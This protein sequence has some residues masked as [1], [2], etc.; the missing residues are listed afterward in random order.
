MK[1]NRRTQ[2]R[3]AF[4]VENFSAIVRG[5]VRDY[6]LAK[7]RAKHLEGLR[8]PKEPNRSFGES[9]VRIFHGRGRHTDPTEM[10]AELKA[11]V[12]EVTQFLGLSDACLK[13]VGKI[14]WEHPTRKGPKGKRALAIVTDTGRWVRIRQK[15][16]VDEAIKLIDE[17]LIKV[18][19]GLPESIKSPLDIRKHFQ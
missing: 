8:N 4:M 7:N 13:R 2:Q 6:V 17:T 15:R 19:Q 16:K 1:I 14:D 11:T 3:K 10:A 5:K 9:E 18:Y 12:I